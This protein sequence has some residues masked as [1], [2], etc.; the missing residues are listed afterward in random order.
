MS[1]AWRKDQKIIRDG[2]ASNT[3][4]IVAAIDEW[5][6]ILIHKERFARA[7]SHEDRVIRLKAPWCQCW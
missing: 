1:A 6:E 5:D 7:V 4:P 2:H 3:Y